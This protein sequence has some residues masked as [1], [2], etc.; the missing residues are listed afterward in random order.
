MVKNLPTIERSTRLRYGK[1]C[2]EDQAENTIVFNASNA[3]IN[4]NVPGSLYLSPIRFRT[5]YTDKSIVLLMYNKR[6]KEITESGEAATDIIE[7]TLQG[8]TLKGNVTANTSVFAGVD[9]NNKLSLLTANSVGIANLTPTS[10]YTLSVG[11]NVFIDDTSTTANLLT[12][13]GDS[14]F[15]GNVVIDGNLHVNGTTTVFQVENIVVKDPILELGQNNDSP[16]TQ[17][18]LGLLL[19]RPE[20][21]S[22]VAFVFNEENQEIM[23]GFTSNAS[24]DTNIVPVNDLNKSMN[25][26]VYGQLFTEESLGVVNTNP[27][28]TL[29]VGSNLYVDD[30]STN[31]LVVTGSTDVS[32]VLTIG[33]NTHIGNELHV[34]NNTHMSRDLTVSGNTYTTG[35]IIGYQDLLITGNTY[36]SGN[37]TIDTELTAIGNVY[38]EKDLE[39]T[40]NTYIS[41]NTNI[42]KILNVTNNVFAKRDMSITGN[43]YAG[44]NTHL[45]QGLHVTG[46]TLLYK[47]LTISGN[48]YAT[49]NVFIDRQLH[50]DLNVYTY[51]D[52]LITGNVFGSSNLNVTKNLN[53]TSNAILK[54]DLLVTGNTYV[55]GNVNV[56]DQLNITGNVY[57][58]KD[59]EITGNAYI[60]GNVNAYKDLL[61]TGNAYVTGNVNVTDQLN[62]TGNVYLSKDI[63]IEG[64][65]YVTGNVVATR[66]ISANKYYGDGG[67]LSN[68]TLQVVT[69]HSNVTS[70]TLHFTNAH[71]AFVTDLTSNVEVKLDQLNNV[72]V[73]TPLESQYL[74]YQDTE[75]WINDYPGQTFLNIYNASADTIYAGNAVYIIQQHNANIV[76]VGLADARDP[77]KMP[78]IGLVW[79]TSIAPGGEGHATTFGKSQAFNTSQFLE[80]ETLY[81]S[82]VYA[83]M[84]SNVKPYGI[85]GNVDKIQNVGIC[86]RVHESSGRV[87]VTGIGRSNDI[88]NANIVTSNATVNYVYVN[89]ANN[90]MKKIDPMKL[91]TKLQTL[92][93]VVNT[94]NVVSNAISVTGLHVTNGG[95]VISSGNVQAGA[96][97]SI[98][99][100]GSKYLPYVSTS[101]YL[102][103]SFIRQEADGRIVIAADLEVDGSV[104]ISGSS[105]EVTSGELVVSDRIINISNGAVTHDLDSGILIE[106]PGHNIGLIHHGG[107]DTFSMGYTQNGYSDDH[108][109]EDSNIF[110][111]DVIGN[112]VVQNT[113]TIESGDLIVSQGNAYFNSNITVSRGLEVSGNISTTSEL[114]VAGNT[115]IGGNT[116]ITGYAHAHGMKLGPGGLSIGNLFSAGPGAVPGVGSV[117]IGGVVQSLAFRTAHDSGYNTGIANTSP[118]HTFSVGANAY[119]NAYGNRTLSIT[120]NTFTTNLFATSN[121]GINI[122]ANENPGYS[123]DV[124]GTSNVATL[125][126]DRTTA[127]TD[128]TTGSLI[129]AGGV[130]ISGALYG[131]AATFDGVT[132]ITNA[133]AA[134]GKTNGALVVTGGTGISGALY[135]AA[136]TFDG[137]T[138]VTNGTAA[139]NKTSGALVVTGGTGIS[140]ALYGAAAT[141]DGVTSVTNAT[142]ATNKTSG[143]LKVTGGVG[144]SGDIYAADA[145][146]D[147]LSVAA[148]TDITG[149]IGRAKVGYIGYSDWGGISH[150]DRASPGNYALIQNG[151]GQTLINCSSGQNIQFREDNAFKMTLSGGNLGIGETSPSTKLHVAGGTIINSDAVAKKTYSYS[152]TISAAT[153]PYINVNFTNYSF[154]AMVVA[155]LIE[156]DEE[157]STIKFE[158]CGGNKS[159]SAPSVNIVPG[160]VSVFGPTSTN[161]WSVL[162]VCNPTRVGIIPTGVLDVDGEYNIFIE[163]ISANSSGG[164]SSIDEDVTEVAAFSY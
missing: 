1:N 39:I 156:S 131:A 87:T 52:L 92:S 34:E 10:D 108:I 157:I 106:H 130:G 163:Y 119:I 147:N 54:K 136:A 77:D 123:L 78:C 50:V 72:T 104:I 27:I 115:V 140:G 98:A 81:V 145:T 133:T 22:N 59:I 26:H 33:N 85:A 150:Y 114:R 141:F 110:T 9:L 117:V 91:P 118:D 12:I 23:L 152:G 41:G 96:N 7:T 101:K 111:L 28:H 14:D 71:T 32:N 160:T 148:D 76:E 62:V 74:I 93:D 16:V 84:L 100:L 70:N 103:D 149:I 44:G 112:V 90:D 161:P 58:S 125:N 137:V 24:T 153:Q 146:F 15:R 63:E 126:V 31:V 82:N 18:D 139:T 49:K 134:T 65:N 144:V 21:K 124:R 142:A 135:G 67:H 11:S 29:D 35:N 43:L 97:V 164:V 151:D 143:A 42:A 80:G 61:L 57:L 3:H 37:V 47:D 73:Q 86:S 60:D 13:I 79:E 128:K 113:I 107:T 102:K 94:G 109:L 45:Y 56:S 17:L 48:V 6:T 99:G 129:V 162:V 121:I 40:G 53:V 2:L 30:L 95:N 127:A 83:G 89:T 75:E 66:D 55:T 132:S 155:Q 69:D 122:P 88:P 25:V 64:N 38:M 116:N 5:D 105:F 120:G 19:H 68:V 8:A 159:G 138:S 4:A 154:T 36:V 158:C 51:K 20:G 46:N